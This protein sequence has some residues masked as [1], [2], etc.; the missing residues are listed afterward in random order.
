MRKESSS[1]KYYPPAIVC[2]AP[3]RLTKVMPLSD[4]RIS[5]EFVDETCGIMANGYWDRL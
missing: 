4:Y 2:L 5:V 1:E 3:W